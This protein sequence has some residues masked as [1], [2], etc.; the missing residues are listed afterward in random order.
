VFPDDSVLAVG[1]HLRLEE[2]VKKTKYWNA[3]E[4]NADQGA[5][6]DQQHV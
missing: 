1:L 4:A 5:Q 3:I 6:M 2:I